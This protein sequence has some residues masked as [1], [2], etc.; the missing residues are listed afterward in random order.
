MLSVYRVTQLTGVLRATHAF[1]V[2]LS[3]IWNSSVSSLSRQDTNRRTVEE[4]MT[5]RPSSRRGNVPC[6]ARVLEECRRGGR[7]CEVLAR[8]RH[9]QRL[10]NARN[11]DQV[12]SAVD[13]P[14]PHTWA[15][16]AV[17]ILVTY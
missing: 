7:E 14:R 6:P 11:S 5:Q 4:R 1:V 15:A 8:G 16:A 13:R 3:L 17:E 2:V 10:I 12:V 9:W